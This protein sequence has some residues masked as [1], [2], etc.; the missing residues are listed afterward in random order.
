[1]AADLDEGER[2]A[3]KPLLAYALRRVRE[4]DEETWKGYLKLLDHMDPA[5]RYLPVWV[6]WAL[7]LER[8]A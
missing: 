5:W 1:M 8:R 6:Q 2:M 4:K 7:Y 3:Y